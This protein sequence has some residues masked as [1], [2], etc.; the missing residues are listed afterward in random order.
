MNVQALQSRIEG[1]V[2]TATDAGYEQLRRSLIWNQLTPGR[3]PQIVVQVANEHDVVEAVRFARSENMKVAVRGGGHSWVGFP[4]RDGSL[5]IDLGRLDQISI[6]PQARM[7]TI[8][9]AVTGREL[10]RQLAA[11]G[12]AFPVGHCPSVPLSGFLLNGGLGWNSN[13][14]GPACFSVEAAH[15]V[16][17]DG[18]LV[19]VNQEEHADL[20]WAIRGAGPGFFGVVTQFVLK[21][22]PVPRAITTSTY[23][24]PLSRMEEVGAWAASIARQLPREVELALFYA[25]APSAYSEPCRSS[26]G[27]V[28]ILTATAF[29]DSQREADETLSLLEN[30]LVLSE[31]LGKEVF[32]PTP[33]DALLDKGGMLWP[34]RHRCLA[35]TFWSNSSPAPPLT[36]MREY[37]LHAPSSKSLGVCVFATGAEDS[38]AVLPDAAFS[39]TAGTLLLCYA[40]W[41]QPEDDG[42]NAAWHRE[43]VAALDPFAVGHYVGE[44][45]IIARPGRGEWSFAPANWQRLRSLRRTYDPDGL[46]HEPFSAG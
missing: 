2:T 31:C 21:L 26:N 5:L 11:H 20:L 46:F 43:I 12:L 45:D 42:V 35:D 13:A 14:W 33:L 15:V 17:A 4:L 22:Y 38:P 23:Y 9:P 41:E 25:Q 34:E 8:Q 29:L 40:I 37:F 36:T 1:K 32:Q 6:D 27:F 28:C 3:Y 24:Y 18:T 44:S 19:V 16:M 39:M 7:A 30:C 10:T